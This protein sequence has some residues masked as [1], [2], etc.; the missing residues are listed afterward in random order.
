MKATFLRP[1]RGVAELCADGV[2]VLGVLSIIAA[3]IWWSPVDVAVFALVL[4]GLVIPRFL[5]IRPALDAAFGIALLVAGWSAVL[6]TYAQVRYWDLVVHFALNGLLAAV[7]YILAVR[8]AVVPDPATEQVSRGAIVSLTVAFGLAAGVVWEV[9][10]WAGHTFVDPT[11]YVGYEDSIGDL[12]VGGLGALVAGL[13]GR[14]LSA[15]SRYIA[16][17]VRLSSTRS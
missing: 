16:T 5:G 7:L 15:E 3:M 12:A 13:A 2:R 9:A 6:D 14:Y 4:L 1:A 11:I 10:E 17:P 8:L